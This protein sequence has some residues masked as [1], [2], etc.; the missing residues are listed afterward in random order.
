M[1]FKGYLLLSGD[2]TQNAHCAGR[3]ER[4]CDFASYEF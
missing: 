4:Y 1:T 2:L 3:F